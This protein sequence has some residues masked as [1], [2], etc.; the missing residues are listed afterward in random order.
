MYSKWGKKYCFCTNQL[1]PNLKRYQFDDYN[2]IYKYNRQSLE[3][4]Y[5]LH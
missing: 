4:K 1:L 5:N 3:V 2:D